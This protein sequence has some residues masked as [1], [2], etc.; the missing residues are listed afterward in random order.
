MALSYFNFSQPRL[1]LY[2]TFRS[3]VRLL[4]LR[5]CLLGLGV[6]PE[7]VQRYMISFKGA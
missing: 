4:A 2:S 7:V 1:E 6:R 5:F 3:E